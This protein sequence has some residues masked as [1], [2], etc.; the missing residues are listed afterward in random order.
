MNLYLAEWYLHYAKSYANE[1]T[2]IAL[3][4]TGRCL[5]MKYEEHFKRYFKDILCEFFALLRA[6]QEIFEFA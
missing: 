3:W 6:V 4:C 1:A 5:N 2:T